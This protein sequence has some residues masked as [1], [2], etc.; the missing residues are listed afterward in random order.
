[1]RGGGWSERWSGEEGVVGGGWSE[2]CCGEGVVRGMDGVRGVVV[3][4]W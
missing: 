4:G 2:R 3:R 1:M